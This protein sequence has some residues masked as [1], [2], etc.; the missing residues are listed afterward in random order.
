MSALDIHSEV[1][2]PTEIDYTLPSS[3]PSARSREVREN[4]INGNNFTVS[5]SSQVL[6]FDI[7][8][9][10]GG[11]YLDP[12]TTYV[13]FKVSYSTPQITTSTPAVLAGTIQQDYFRL[14][15]SSY[16][17]IYKEFEETILQF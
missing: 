9:G 17:F 1:T 2:I 16:S 5:T 7:P 11:D 14:L 13:R 10:N 12:T 15:G 6:Q 4:P 3:L 8:C